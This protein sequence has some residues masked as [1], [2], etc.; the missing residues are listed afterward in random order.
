MKNV[1]ITGANS[2]IGRAA[3]FIFANHG[4][5]VIMAC[6][7]IKKSDAVCQEI[8]AKT[9][10]NYIDLL[11]LDLS[12]SQSIN[13]FCEVY[14]KK[15][16]VVDIL[17]NNA[18]HFSH[19]E[20]KLQ[21]SIDGCE[22]TFATNL[23]GPM[24]LSNLLLDVLKKSER[25]IILNACSTNIKHFFNNKRKIDFNTLS[26]QAVSG[27][28]YNSYQLYG[29]SKIGLLMATIF[30]ARVYKNT[31]VRVNAIMIPATKMSKNTINNFKPFW[32]FLAILQNPFT[33]KPE[34]IGN[35]Y[36][37]ICSS[38]AFAGITGKL[39]NH[40]GKIVNAADK[41]MSFIKIVTG[42]EVYPPYADDEEA[43]ERV[44]NICNCYI[45]HKY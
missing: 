41:S 27:Q 37:S 33:P 18:G 15:Y 5:R 12:S 24:L 42:S 23:L 43:C 34:V 25:P 20:T 19:G 38:N 1:I 2:G 26:G 13:S 22:L 44:W 6:R 40:H 10:N 8:K 14:M 39:I 35:A 17:I 45:N 36:F 21:Q 28:K 16:D 30:M 7:N 4:H 3:A 9:K 11:Q 31:N 29:D 32:R